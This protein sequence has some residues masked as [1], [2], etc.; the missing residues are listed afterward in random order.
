MAV[1]VRG[2]AASGAGQTTT[3]ASLDFPLP[4]G[5]VAG[6]VALVCVQVALGTGQ[7]TTPTGW[8]LMSGP[9]R[10][11]TNVTSQLF[12]KTLVSGDAGATVTFAFDGGARR[13]SGTLV[14]LADVTATGLT[15]G[16]QI[17]SATVDSAVLPTLTGVAAGSALVAFSNR[18]V[19]S[20]TVPNVVWPAEYTPLAEAPTAYTSTP[21]LN[22]EAAFQL[23]TAGGSYNG[24][25]TLDRSSIG[26][27]YLVAL[28]AG[29]ASPPTPVPGT[30]TS[31]WLGV[32]TLV[33]RTSG[34][35]GTVR[36]A[37]STSS[38]MTSPTY[39]TAATPNADGVTKHTVPTTLA[40]NTAHWYQV[41]SAGTLIGSPQAFRT[42]PGP[43]AASYRFVYGSC[44]QHG[45]DT[46]P[47]LTNMLTRDPDLFLEIGDLHY[48]NINQASVTPYL[49]AYDEVSARAALAAVLQK[50]PN[51]YM[52][53][54]HDLCGDGSYKG[55]VGVPYVQAAYRARVPHTTLPS[56]QG[57]VQHTF[58]VGRV[59]YIVLDCRSLRDDNS[60]AD[61]P[62]KSMLGAE[63][64]AWLQGLL[65][66]PD[67]PLTFIASSVGWIGVGGGG[68]D[69]WGAYSTERA[70]IGAWIAAAATKVVFLCGD[71]HMLAYDD[72]TNSV[73]GAPVWHAAAIHQSASE[74]GGPYSGGTHPGTD[75]Y[76][77][78]AIADNGTTVTATWNGILADG[79]T[80][81]TT[82][83]SS[84][85]APAPPT[86]TL[87]VGTPAQS[88]ASVSS[89]NVP[90]TGLTFT[91]GD[92]LLLFC[93]SNASGGG[94]AAPAGYSTL[95]ASTDTVNGSTSGHGAVYYK[96]ASAGEAAPTVTLASGRVG[97]LPIKA[98]GYDT[99]TL[100]AVAAAVTQAA[101]GATSV[102]APSLTA[103]ADGTLVTVHVGRNGSNGAPP[104]WTPPSGMTE[105]GEA[106][107]NLTSST[108]TS[109]EVSFQEVTSGTATGSKAATASLAT[110]GAFGASFL[111]RAATVVTPKTG[112]GSGS[113]T[114]AGA[115]VGKRTPRSSGTGSWAFVGSGTGRRV[116]Q[117]SGAGGWGF[118]GTGAGSKTS[119]GAGSGLLAWAG[120]GTGAAPV[121]TPAA[122]HG[123]G[124]W[125]FAGS[126]SGTT[127]R[128]GTGAGLVSWA[129]TGTGKRTAGATGAG[130]W[131][132]T[133]TGTGTSPGTTP[134][135]PHVYVTATLT[136]DGTSTAV[137]TSNGTGTA[138]LAGNGQSTAALTPAAVTA[139]LDT[140]T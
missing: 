3:V 19:G 54:D 13:M 92:Y 30:L 98:T 56:T 51:S 2:S 84:V 50:I 75:Q 26:S 97:V 73:G 132:F 110:Q 7:F 81:A 121:V 116:P 42:L 76:A 22:S 44:R 115:G 45:T 107:G 27:Q 39:S 15:V 65:A 117:A 34:A 41:E 135:T 8:T 59:R 103:P 109:L 93:T 86:R 130:T 133:G 52:Y 53:D 14:V 4:A 58:R 122:G 87:T 37:F 85:A 18:R 36:V 138:V 38:A 123:G 90:L 102:A 111:L 80:W 95:L 113:W 136:G 24:T 20:T 126:G 16:V 128:R 106:G 49:A 9:D 118:T 100:I 114:F 69:H 74:K 129:G 63:Q 28:P 40:A 127:Q 139:T 6:D 78:V 68:A 25:A 47:A 1:S 64:K 17:D 21:Q 96:A 62:N 48:Q 43:G 66:A 71:A 33:A 125:T 89:I 131:T 61:G 119:R 72:G 70:Q 11:S 108:N 55:M 137:L 12:V 112:S 88:T 91:T 124:T 60:I 77:D 23:A 105:L 134:Y 35:T 99:S 67:T 120:A 140:T 46:L 10:I 79:S 32:D 104:T 57:G 94:L 29:V 82:S 5:V 31:T 101:S 83:A